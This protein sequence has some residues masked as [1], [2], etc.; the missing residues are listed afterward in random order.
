[1]KFFTKCHFTEDNIFFMIAIL[2]QSFLSAYETQIPLAF[3]L[4][5]PVFMIVDFMMFERNESE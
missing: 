1:M 2:R 5:H 4:H 3:L